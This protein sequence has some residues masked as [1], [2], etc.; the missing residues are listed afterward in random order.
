MFQE[1]SF[2]GIFVQDWNFRFFRV[3]RLF[4]EFLLQASKKSKTVTIHLA[5]AYVY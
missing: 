5:V 2:P 4:Q 1:L 3:N